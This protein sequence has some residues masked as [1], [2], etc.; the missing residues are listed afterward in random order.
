MGRQFVV[1]MLPRS[2]SVDH[3][4]TNALRVFCSNQR[5]DECFSRISQQY[6][7]MLNAYLFN[8]R[9]TNEHGNVWTLVVCNAMK[10]VMHVI[11]NS[12]F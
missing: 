11:T 7:M 10:S 9:L 5:Y 6:S 4:P 8:K 1:S 12:K 3:P 2:L